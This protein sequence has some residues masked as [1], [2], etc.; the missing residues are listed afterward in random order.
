MMQDSAVVLYWNP[1]ELKPGEKREVGFSYGLGLVS[2]GKG[3]AL[4]VTVGGSFTPGG[5]LTV[6]ALVSSPQPGQMLTLDLPPG[7]TR[8]EGSREQPVPQAMAGRPSPV[9]WRIRSSAT[10][11]FELKVRSS[12]GTEQKRSVTIKTNTIF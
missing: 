12:T 1:R 5:E 8:V 7:F 10:G 11:R 9:T 2:S 6:V 4:G 3:G